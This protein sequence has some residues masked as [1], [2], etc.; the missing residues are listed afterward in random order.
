VFSSDSIQ[1]LQEPLE[2]R[3]TDLEGFPVGDFK[4]GSVSV[5]EGKDSF[6]AGSDQSRLWQQHSKQVFGHVWTHRDIEHCWLWILQLFWSVQLLQGNGYLVRWA[7]CHTNS[8]RKYRQFQTE[9][10]WPFK[11]NF[12]NLGNSTLSPSW[13]CP[14]LVFP[15]LALP[16]RSIQHYGAQADQFKA[17]DQI[18]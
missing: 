14:S 18:T 2:G 7:R 11:Q 3:L 8:T 5:G 9:F 6:E 12:F 10:S 16:A 17:I 13:L 4:V 1:I 15:C